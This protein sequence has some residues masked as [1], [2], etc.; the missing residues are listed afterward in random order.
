MGSGLYDVVLVPPKHIAA[1][2]IEVSRQLESL[3]TKFTLQDGVLFP[4]LSLYIVQLDDSNLDKV[5]TILQKIAQKTAAIEMNPKGYSCIMD[6]LFLEYETNA[7]VRK[8]HEAVVGEI[9]PLRDGMPPKDRARLATLPDKQKKS[10]EQFGW[11]FAGDLYQAHISITKFN[12]KQNINS[13]KLPDT[14]SF[15]GQ[16]DIL[17]LFEVGENGTCTRQVAEFKLREL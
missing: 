2:A 13:L 6:F 1:K 11:R 8:L 17:G 9:A 3:G 16:F 5:Q 10:L 15:A 7:K 12:Y 14:A 4:H